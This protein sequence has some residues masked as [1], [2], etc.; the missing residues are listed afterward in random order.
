[1]RPATIV[2][3]IFGMA[4]SAGIVK[5]VGVMMSATTRSPSSIWRPRRS[6]GATLSDQAPFGSVALSRSR[7]TWSTMSVRLTTPVSRPAASSTG[8]PE[9]DFS[10]KYEASSRTVHDSRTART[11]WIMMS[12]AVLIFFISLPVGSVARG[13]ASP[14]S[15]AESSPAFGL[16]GST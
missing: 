4:V 7:V 8:A 5:K 3:A 6:S 1:M 12:P 15:A 13:G 11:G 2:R 9:I 10:T 16:L 14:H